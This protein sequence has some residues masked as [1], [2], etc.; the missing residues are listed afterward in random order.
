MYGDPLAPA[1]GI[2]YGLV[3]SAGIW[4]IIVWALLI[5]QLN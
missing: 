3:I 5:S 4:A 2:L 1:R